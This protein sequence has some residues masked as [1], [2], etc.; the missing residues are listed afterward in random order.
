[1]QDVPV[2]EFSRDKIDKSLAES[3]EEKSLV[4]DLL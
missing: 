3:K 1:V 2:N 4:N